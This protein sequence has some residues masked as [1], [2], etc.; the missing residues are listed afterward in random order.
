MSRRGT[1]V[2]ETRLW[3]GALLAQ[4]VVDFFRSL[5]LKWTCDRQREFGQAEM[6][7]WALPLDVVY[8]TAVEA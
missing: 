5:V 2:L 7:V 3:R 4:V 8:L 1:G 6:A